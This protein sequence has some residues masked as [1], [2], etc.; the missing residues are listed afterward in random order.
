MNIRSV[1]FGSIYDFGEGIAHKPET[2]E[3]LLIFTRS[4]ALVRSHSG[5]IEVPEGTFILCGD[6]GDWECS[7]Q[8]L[9]LL[10]DWICFDI[11]GNTQDVSLIAD[12]PQFLPIR[13]ADVELISQLMRAAAEEFYSL[14]PQR[15]KMIDQPMRMILVDFSR[16]MGRRALQQQSADPHYSALIE[17]RSK[18]YRNPQ[19]RWNVDSMAADVNMSRSYFQHIY[20]EFFGVSCISD[21]IAGKIEKAKE[22]LSE[23]DCTVSQVAVMCGYENEEHFMRQFKKVVGV[24]PTGFRKKS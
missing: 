20:R 10:C 7:P 22:I 9:P 4:R 19:Q 15:G 11:E 6:S 17:L 18:I 23:T 24:T 2:G 8:E 14:D 3:F 16:V 21:V 12:I 1:G 13:S 5:K